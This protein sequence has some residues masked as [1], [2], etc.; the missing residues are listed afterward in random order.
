[1]RKSGLLFKK[2]LPISL[3]VSLLLC[4]MPLSFTVHAA[5]GNDASQ[6]E[7][8]DCTPLILPTSY[9]NTYQSSD[10]EIDRI[11][12]ASFL[13]KGTTIP[14]KYDEREKDSLTPVRNQGPFGTCWAHAALACVE[15]SISKQNLA[16]KETLNFSETALAHFTYSSITDPLGGTEGDNNSI[17]TSYMNK[18]GNS[19]SAIYA[20]AKWMGVIQ[21]SNDPSLAYPYPDI[22]DPNYIPEISDSYAYQCD[23]HLQ[24]ARFFNLSDVDFVKQAIME[25]GTL[26]ASYYATGNSY[27]DNETK[28]CVYYQNSYSKLTNHAVTLVGWDDNFPREKFHEDCRPESDGAWLFRNSWGSSENQSGYFW[29]PYEEQTFGTGGVYAIQVEK[30]SNYDHNYQYD[31]GIGDGMT[32]VKNHSSIANVFTAHGN[33]DGGEQ[34]NAV[35]FFLGTTNVSYTIDIYTELE[36]LASPDSGTL[37]STQ[38]GVT[39]FAGYYTI[40][41][42]TPVSLYEGETFSVVITLSVPGGRTASILYHV[43]TDYNAINMTID[44]KENLGES[45]VK[46]QYA[47]NWTDTASSSSAYTNRIK[48][49]TINTGNLTDFSLNQ[50]EV[51]LDPFN[52]KNP[53]TT[54]LSVTTVSPGDAPTD[55]YWES[56]D[57]SIATVDSHGLVTA[58]R[59]G[60]TTITATSKLNRACQRVCAIHVVPSLMGIEL[61][62]NELQMDI[63][64]TKTL[65]ILWNPTDFAGNKTIDWT[66]S[67]TSVATVSSGVVE[68]KASG[69]TVI[70][71]VL[72]DTPSIYAQC[73]VT[74]EHITPSPTL[75]TQEPVI[76][77]SPAV[78]TATD[79]SNTPVPASA[80]PSTS[81]NPD[82]SATPGTSTAPTA[83]EISSTPAPTLAP[84]ETPYPYGTQKPTQTPSPEPSQT[85][86]PS[87]TRSPGEIPSESEAPPTKSPGSENSG[88]DDS[89]QSTASPRHTISPDDSGDNSPEDEMFYFGYGTYRV[90]DDYSVEFYGTSNRNIATYN[91]PSM[92]DDGQYS[93]TVVGVA[94][95]AL[96]GN[97][98]VRIVKLAGTITSIGEGAFR[99]CPNL[100][101]VICQS[102]RCDYVGANAF[103]NCPRLKQITFK[104]VLLTKSN[105][106]ANCFAKTKKGLVCIIPKNRYKTYK[107][108]FKKKGNSSI[109]L[110]K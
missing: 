36:D 8:E 50:K 98:S 62:D 67:N 2:I 63:N 82:T 58:V 23:Y 4:D 81:E 105:M 92:V 103:S 30:A 16:P 101:K 83:T 95:E 29:I 1:M 47:K 51:T 79:I 64:T 106:G 48:A 12:G 37:C 41:L 45:F 108:F 54:Q 5:A 84:D 72:H 88:K 89:V 90:I 22:D 38:T 20:M 61:S 24:N 77:E 75:S 34:L 107:K 70:T 32:S 18:G 28:D 66:S 91:I 69:T 31:G 110:K 7:T 10:T 21:E 76:T 93:Y 15:S 39:D 53:N 27:V 11:T 74:V 52:G 71:A 49:F 59:A 100:R 13:N 25:Y 65:N 94:K 109:K 17:S 87:P 44:V 55:M 104:S 43:D 102:K 57:P 6:E 73:R 33:S 14:S 9:R 78:P 46:G 99:N 80:G 96:R 42:S 35:S 85:P 26:M 19:M 86:V 3:A 97:T 56:A 60:T 40:P 68:A